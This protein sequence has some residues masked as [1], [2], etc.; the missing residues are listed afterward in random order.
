MGW[1]MQNHSTLEVNVLMYEMNFITLSF[2][3][4]L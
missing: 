3:G 2:I 1:N 4:E